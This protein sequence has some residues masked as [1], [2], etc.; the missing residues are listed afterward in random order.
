MAGWIEMFI[1][2]SDSLKNCGLVQKKSLPNMSCLYLSFCWIKKS[3]KMCLKVTHIQ[4]RTSQWKK[5]ILQWGSGNGFTLIQQMTTCAATELLLHPSGWSEESLQGKRS[6]RI[7]LEIRDVRHCY[8]QSEKRF[9]VLVSWWAMC[10]TLIDLV[11]FKGHSGMCVHTSW[12]SDY[13]PLQQLRERPQKLRQ[14]T[15]KFNTFYGMHSHGATDSK[16][17]QQIML[18]KW[19]ETLEDL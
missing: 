17:L 19:L 14:V 16:H 12:Y 13:L 10:K 6:G 18:K 3:K 8:A 11:V 9:F 7:R 2:F 5:W 4:A 15:L 1:S